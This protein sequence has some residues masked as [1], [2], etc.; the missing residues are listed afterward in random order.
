MFIYNNTVNDECNNYNSHFILEKKK[1][2]K[3][4]I[5]EDNIF[6]QNETYR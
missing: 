2:E 3:Y 4:C 6:K 5:N 1:N